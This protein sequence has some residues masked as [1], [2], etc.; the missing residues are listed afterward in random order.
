MENKKTTRKRKEFY[1]NFLLYCARKNCGA[2]QRRTFLNCAPNSSDGTAHLLGFVPHY[3]ISA[4]AFFGM[5]P[6]LWHNEWHSWGCCYGIIRAEI[7]ST[8]R[9]PAG[10]S[11][12]APFDDNCNDDDDNPSWGTPP[13]HGRRK[14]V[15][16]APEGTAQCHENWWGGDGMG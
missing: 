12:P 1:G 14:F 2:V 6:L 10:S 4:T 11:S 3:G 15:S 8:S 13:P 16:S 5:P 9:R 7:I